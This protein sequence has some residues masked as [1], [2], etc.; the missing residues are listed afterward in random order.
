VTRTKIVALPLGAVALGLWLW[1]LAH[2]PALVND[3]AFVYL[4]YAVNWVDHGVLA[5]NRAGGS[6]D[7]FTSFAWQALAALAYRITRGDPLAAL[8]YVAAAAS[9]ATVLATVWLPLTAGFE[10]SPRPRTTIAAAFA[11]SAVSAA[12]NPQFAFYTHSL[13]ESGLVALAVCLASW[14][15]ARLVAGPPASAA[16]AAL[17]GGLVGALA[18]VRPEGLL[19]AAVL[20]ALLALRLA[21]AGLS[22][23]P[24]RTLLPALEPR[25]RAALAAA[26]V[27]ASLVAGSYFTWHLARYGHPLPNPVYVK[28][29]GVSAVSIAQGLRY[30]VRGPQGG[31][32]PMAHVR[33]TA[34]TPAEPVPGETVHAAVTP[35]RNPVSSW[36]LLALVPLLWLISFQGP[37]FFTPHDA[38]FLVGFLLVPT[39]W[40]ALVVLAGGDPPHSGWRFVT[41][42]LPAVTLAAVLAIRSSR[43]PAAA[44]LLTAILALLLARTA[45]VALDRPQRCMQAASACGVE[46]IRRWPPSLA[47][48]SWDVSNSWF[49]RRVAEALGAS[50]PPSAVIGQ[51]DFL[52]IGA[53]LPEYAIADLSG[54]TDAELAHAPHPADVRLFSS[55][56]L[57][58]RRPDVYIYGYRFIS[59]RNLARYR[60]DD[61]AV[62]DLLYPWPPEG[63]A[64]G[65]Q[66]MVRLY[67]GASVRFPNG[68]WF[69]FLVLRQAVG[70]MTSREHVEVGP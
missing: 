17:D 39:G 48:Y 1:N 30:L 8:G 13:M 62:G 25:A 32:L 37:S 38:R 11:A 45:Y 23:E 41:P 40:L 26:F 56:L 61:P 58:A 67:A 22:A 34:T 12:L 69:N 9:A 24:I 2:V 68:T 57:V 65:F 49:D 46:A 60:L 52:R 5:W 59:D 47:D 29:S 54:L 3:D 36:T 21:C 31:T 55:D 15:A 51:S 66:E 4:R 50:F 64:Q 33:S 42:L 10:T 16:R 7:G 27:T 70:S 20:C 44:G 63:S 18:L 35:D 14:A 43:L 6:G 53:H 19:V 28:T